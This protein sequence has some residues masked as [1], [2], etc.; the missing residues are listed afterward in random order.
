VDPTGG[1]CTGVVTVGV[2]ATRDST[3]VDDGPLYDSTQP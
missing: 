3:A 2:P 1:A